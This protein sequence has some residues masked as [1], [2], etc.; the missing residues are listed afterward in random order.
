MI[1]E[2]CLYRFVEE[3]NCIIR[4]EQGPAEIQCE[5]SYR[6]L[7]TPDIF[8]SKGTGMRGRKDSQARTN[9][10]YSLSLNRTGAI[11]KIC[12]DIAQQSPD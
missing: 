7:D 6:F 8:E 5:T 10:V 2:P 1:S 11:L 12:N 4:Q 9:L 3:L